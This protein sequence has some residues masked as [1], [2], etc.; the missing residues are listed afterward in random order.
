MR[1]GSEKTLI[2]VKE[3]PLALVNWPAMLPD[4]GSL[5]VR[6]NLPAMARDSHLRTVPDWPMAASQPVMPLGKAKGS[7]PED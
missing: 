7:P 2:A 3:K 4:S 6:V 5:P 1:Q